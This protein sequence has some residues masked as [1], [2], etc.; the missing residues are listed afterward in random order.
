VRKGQPYPNDLNNFAPR[1]SLAWDPFGKGKTVVRA[2]LGVYYDS[3]PFDYLTGQAYISAHN[4]GPAYNP[5]APNPIFQGL[6]SPQIL[7]AGQPIFD[8][9][10]LTPPV[11]P[12]TMTGTLNCDTLDVSTVGRLRTPYIYNFSLNVQ[13]ELTRNTVLQVGFLGTQGRKLPRLVD[14]NQPSPAAIT[15]FDATCVGGLG[16]SLTNCAL[17][18]MVP[19]NFNNTAPFLLPGQNDSAANI[20][21]LVPQTPRYL[22]QLQTTARSAYNSMFV[23]LVQRDWHGITQQITYT[24][25]H[26]ID[27]A[28]DGV[29]FVPH[30]AQPNDST[31]PHNSGLGNS[32]FDIR[33]HFVWTF[34]Y[35]LP[36][37]H[38][39]GRLGEGW[40][41]TSTAT[42][43]TGFPVELVNTADN[44]DGS[45]E[46][47]GRPDVVGPVH[48]N[49]DNP[50]QYLAVN[51]FAVPCTLD[52][53]GTA[54]VNCLS[55]SRHFGKLGRNALISPPFRQWD[56]SLIKNTKLTERFTL[57]L[58]ADFYNILNHP[59]FAN[60]L[61]PSF[62]S[63]LSGYTVCQA[64]GAG[65]PRG[66]QFA[67]GQ[68]LP[69]TATVD[70]G[71]G[72][73]ILGSG[74]PRSIQ[75]AFKIIF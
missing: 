26:S 62:I 8:N 40:S 36:K 52:G 60:P 47:F 44:Y 72:N 14:L 65:C 17:G 71:N 66:G 31:S 20:S 49:F 57:Q 61:L 12:C 64:A 50:S 28:S 75:F 33:N 2:G 13:Q 68:F 9:T 54:A 5:V 39:L 69:I 4:L 1:L 24:W 73:P 63:D 29:D 23:S 42:L 21:D 45:G 59:N 18:T 34:N 67:A 10:L 32:N 55:G 37:A 30:A 16:I 38:S 6:P 56:L 19:P 58:R 51:A 74:G 3:F 25:S 43:M 27:D 15:A 22:Q 46:F 11:A 48:Y 41:I 7:A 53:T 35:A 70:T